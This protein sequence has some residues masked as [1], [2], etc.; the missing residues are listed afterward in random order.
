MPWPTTDVHFVHLNVATLLYSLQMGVYITTTIVCDHHWV[1]V[2][3]DVH[4]HAFCSQTP[5]H[6][7]VYRATRDNLT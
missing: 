2:M 1:S 7:I 4:V 6:V 5:L 3:G